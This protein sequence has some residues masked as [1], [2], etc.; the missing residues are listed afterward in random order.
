MGANTIFVGL[1]III[2]PSRGCLG[3]Y[4]YTSLRHN[5]HPFNYSDV[6][7]VPH[8]GAALMCYI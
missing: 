3:P 1:H 8:S 2:C 4:D 6:L 7:L 5:T